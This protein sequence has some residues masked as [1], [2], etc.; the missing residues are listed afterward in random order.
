MQQQQAIRMHVKTE[1]AV[2]MTNCGVD[3]GGGRGGCLC[4]RGWREKPR[5]R[6]RLFISSECKSRE[7]ARRTLFALQ[8]SSLSSLVRPPVSVRVCLVA[9]V[10][11]S[12]PLFALLSLSS[13]CLGVRLYV[14]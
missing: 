1:A 12:V 10:C 13:A 2:C 8:L 3:L 11:V 14:D 5:T 4:C 7:S 6:R 9:S